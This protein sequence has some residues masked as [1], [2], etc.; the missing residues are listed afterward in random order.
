MKRFI[1]SLSF[2]ALLSTIAAAQ[3]ASLTVTNQGNVPVILNW[4]DFNGQEQTYQTIEPQKQAVQ[5]TYVGHQWRIRVADTNEVL[6]NITMTSIAQGIGVAKMV[7]DR[8]EEP[9]PPKPDNPQEFDENRFLIESLAVQSEDVIKALDYLNAIRTNPAA[10]TNLHPSLG[11]A[12][13]SPTHKLRF[14]R[15]LNLA[16][17]RKARWMAEN[18]LGNFNSMVHVMTINGEQ[19]G[20]NQWMREARYQLAPYLQ[21]NQT[22]FECLHADGGQGGV[23]GAVKRA[24]N[25]WMSEGKDGGHVLPTLGRGWWAPCDDIGIGVARSANGTIF[26][27]VLVGCYD[28]FQP[29]GGV[30]PGTTL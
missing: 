5:Q 18:D 22:N 9:K 12:D 6:S 26:V 29:N 15:R 10:F 25:S 16:A 17:Q 19:V 30:E 21:N 3:E 1:Y 20:M 4:I 11:D 8:P 24:I 23:E 28:P 27:S 14:D 13:V 2:V 7:V